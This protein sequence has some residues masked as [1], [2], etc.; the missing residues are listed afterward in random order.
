MALQESKALVSARSELRVRELEKENSWA[1]MLPSLEFN[2]RQN[3]QDS[4]SKGFS[5]RPT[6]ELSL[7]LNQNIYDNGANWTQYQSAK[8]KTDIASLRFSEER[9]KLILSVAK[10][11]YNYSLNWHLNK[12]K[13]QQLEII[14]K[15]FRSV[16]SQFHQGIRTRGDFL[17]SSTELRRA[18]IDFEISQTSLESS[19]LDLI[20]ILGLI[21]DPLANTPPPEASKDIQFE[22]TEIIPTLLEKIPL[23]AP[24]ITLHYQY[25]AALLEKQIA[26]N[27]LQLS[28]R[29]EWPELFV[30]A[31]ASYYLQD[32]ILVDK[33][34]AQRDS[35]DWN[36]TFNLNFNLWDWGIRKRN[37]GIAQANKL[38]TEAQLEGQLQ[39]IIS[40]NSKLILSLNQ[41][42]RNL[43]LAIQLLELEKKS[44]NFLNTEYQNGTASYTDI[45]I[46]LKNLLES[47]VQMATSY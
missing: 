28:R 22:P 3:Y 9:D 45:T 12:V 15:Q 23:S 37:R 36:V 1:L 46:G 40:E 38:K 7:Q 21:S 34:S 30:K 2:A 26:E 20:K 29:K 44:F 27:D 14:R 6:S 19:R 10:E 35:T 4:N 43:K 39:T 33:T 16:S 47:K 18:E 17:Q 42:S 31:G 32:S 24:L 5:L 25:K 8:L 41:S 11:F 13:I